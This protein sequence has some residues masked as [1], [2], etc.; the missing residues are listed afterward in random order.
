MKCDEI[1]QVL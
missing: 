1:I